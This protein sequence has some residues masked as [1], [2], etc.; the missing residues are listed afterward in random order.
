MR[1][2]T[3]GPLGKTWKDCTL[4]DMLMILQPSKDELPV[5]ITRLKNGQ[6]IWDKINTNK[7]RL[8]PDDKND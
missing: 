3:I 6:V 8:H 5:L 4:N 2:Q 7:Y 1:I